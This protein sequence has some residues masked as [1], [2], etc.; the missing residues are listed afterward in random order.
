MKDSFYVVIKECGS[1][2]IIILDP[3]AVFLGKQV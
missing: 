2:L 1:P 3:I